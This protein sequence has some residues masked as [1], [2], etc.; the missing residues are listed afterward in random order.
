LMKTYKPNEIE[1]KSF[2]IISKELGN[3]ELDKFKDPIIKSIC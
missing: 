1:M 2:E 3:I